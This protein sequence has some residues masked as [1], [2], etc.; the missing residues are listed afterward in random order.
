MSAVIQISRYWHT[1]R[2]LR[3]G[4]FVHR[5]RFRLTRPSPDLSPAPPL[6]VCPGRWVR[7]AERCASMIA[8]DR[9]RFL[10]EEH[11]LSDW[12]DPALPKLWRYNLHYF[13]DLNAEGAGERHAWHEALMARWIAENPPAAGSGWEPYPTSLRIVNWVKYALAGHALTPAA[14]NSL[15]AQARWLSRRIEWHLLG[16]HLFAN[17]KALVFAGCFFS[18]PE[19]E[20]WRRR[21]LAILDH[22]YGEQFCSDGGHFERSTMYHALALEDVLDL[23]NL[24]RAYGGEFA[25]PR[26]GVAQ[27]VR[28]WLAAMTHP[29]GEIGFFNDAAIGIAPNPAALE[30]YAGRLGLPALGW[31]KRPVVDLSDSGYARVEIGPLVALIDKAPLGP[32]YLPG[33]GH[34]DTLSFELSLYGQRLLVNSGT[35][36]Y[37]E[38]A[39]RL[40]Q[41]GTAAHSTVVIDGQNS[42]EV[43][44]GF[45]VARRA[46]VRNERI[47]VQGKGVS[48]AAEHDGYTRLPG[49]P[50]HRREWSFSA[51]RLKVVDTVSGTFASAVAHFHFHPAIRL[52]RDVEGFAASLP[53]GQTVRI[54]FVGGDPKLIESRWHPEFGL[55]LAKPEL[56][57]HLDR[58]TLTTTMSWS[59]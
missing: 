37:G 9:F 2:Y 56:I 13:D 48:V 14:L 55:S 40:R 50:V 53:G 41:R 59:P 26:A 25:E 34:A 17:A 6:G 12:D 11:S 46:R 49:R 22:E 4:Q 33:H 30:A 58:D 5:L 3:P 15:A 42:S 51:D 35:S 57:V 18:G 8:P 43:W 52:M 29:D 20:D 7:P 54:R 47:E 16:N 24:S 23:L 39:E 28:E 27:A 38:S 19:A 45:R 1:L 44:S 36:L 31:V 10:N 21:G 32:D